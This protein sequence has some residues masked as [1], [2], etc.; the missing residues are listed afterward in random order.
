MNKSELIDK[1]ASE[2]ECTKRETKRTVECIFKNIT[3]CLAKGDAI[4]LVGFGTFGIRKR[5]ARE[6]RNPLTGE[7]VSV[8]AKSVPFFKAGKELKDRVK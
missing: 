8:P 4:K 2:I 7:K 3:D 6:A 1:V 5:E